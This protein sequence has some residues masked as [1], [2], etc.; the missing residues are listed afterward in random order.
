MSLSRSAARLFEEPKV[1]GTLRVPSAGR[2]GLRHTECAYYFLAA[3]AAAPA[4][5]DSQLNPSIHHATV[6][7]LSFWRASKLEGL[8]V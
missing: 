2:A 1:A 8:I 6:R 3:D 5:A 7:E 4:V